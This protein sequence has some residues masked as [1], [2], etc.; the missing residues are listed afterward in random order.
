[1]RAG[2]LGGAVVAALLA[3]GCPEPPEPVDPIFPEDYRGFY[4]MVR[5]CRRSIEHDL[6]FVQVWAD[7]TSVDAYVTREGS[8][9]DGSLI[10]KEEFRDE[11]CS[12][13]VGW[14]VM[15]REV[16]YAPEAGD[17]HW[18][19]VADDRTVV[20][21]GHLVDCFLCHED[22]GRPPEGFDWTCAVE[23]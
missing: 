3:T 15:R 16:G 8:F 17:W 5:D 4:T 10:V 22:C 6:V 18:Q 1:M 12:D 2:R 9:P 14:A 19:E 20:L 13:M 21:D 7:P 11:A 23:E